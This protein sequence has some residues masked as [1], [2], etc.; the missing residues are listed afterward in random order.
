VSEGGGNIGERF[1]V[2][3]AACSHIH[4]DL[5]QGRR[6]LAEAIAQSRW[7]GADGGPSFEWG[8]MLYLGDVFGS[9]APRLQLPAPST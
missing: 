8:I 3:A 4:S 2:W 5:K 9:G 6:S 7:G 1:A